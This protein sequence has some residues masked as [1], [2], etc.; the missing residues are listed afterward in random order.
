MLEC[1]QPVIA[2]FQA[3]IE[4]LEITLPVLAWNDAGE[5]YVLGDKALILASTAAGF[6]GL[7]MQGEGRKRDPRVP[8]PVVI[9]PR[10][11]RT[12]DER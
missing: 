2:V 11:P 7:R 8:D 9:P 3:D 12:K 6:Q 10:V 4:K 5:P 1:T